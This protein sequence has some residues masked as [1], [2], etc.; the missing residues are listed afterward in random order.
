VHDLVGGPFPADTVTVGLV[1]SGL[2]FL[3][4]ALIGM[5]LV[6]TS[7]RGEEQQGHHGGI[8]FPF[9][10]IGAFMFVVAG[11]SEQLLS[12]RALNQILR[13]TMFRECNMFLWIYGF[14]SFTVFGSM[15]YIIPRLLDFG[16]RSSLLIKI[17]YYASLYGILL[18]LALVGGGGI[19]QGLVLESTDPLVTIVNANQVSIGFYIANTMCISLISIGNGVFA[20]HLGWMLLD[21]LRL[22][23]RENRLASEILLEPYEP[24]PAKTSQEASA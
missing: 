13:F 24:A 21:W 10:V 16:W 15:Y 2:I 12:V 19:F 18:F 22:R 14:F 20:L 4:V 1:L 17:H 8:V 11:I 7:V 3:P 9:L 6:G 5:N 23:V